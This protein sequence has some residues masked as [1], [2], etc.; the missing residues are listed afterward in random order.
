MKAVRKLLLSRGDAR[1]LSEL[2]KI[3]N[4]EEEKAKRHDFPGIGV[5]LIFAAIIAVIITW[6]LYNPR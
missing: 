1:L 2:V 6:I 4:L 5:I 3:M